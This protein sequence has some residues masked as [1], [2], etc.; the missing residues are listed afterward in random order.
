MKINIGCGKK[1]LEGYLNCDISKEVKPDKIIDLEK[2][3]SFKDNSIDEV[4]GNHIIECVH[5]FIPLMHELRRI[6]RNG[7]LLK[8]RVLFYSYVGAY[9]DP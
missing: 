2:P 8:F 5:N 7:A 3:L 9:S 1:K 4:V 6:C